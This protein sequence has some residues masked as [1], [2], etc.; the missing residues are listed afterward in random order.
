MRCL[1]TARCDSV[2]HL[3][4]NVPYYRNTEQYAYDGET[5]ETLRETFNGLESGAAEAK[6]YTMT[7][8]MI[9]ASWG[10]NLSGDGE[11][12]LMTVI[13]SLLEVEQR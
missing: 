3:T 7:H 13:D 11:K 9:H 12:S 1:V 8:L 5:F 6:S 2:R 4:E 10:W